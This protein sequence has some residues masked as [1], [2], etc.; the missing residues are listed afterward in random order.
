MADNL[1]SPIKSFYKGKNVFITGAT[2]FVGVT[3]VEKLLRDIP[4]IGTVYLLMRPKKGKTVA[5]RLEEIRKNSVFDKFKELTLYEKRFDKI[6]TIEGDV[7]QEHL[8]ISEAERQVLIDNVHVVFHSAATLDFFQS[9]KETTNINLLGTRRVVELCKQLTKLEALV[10]VSSA[11]VNSYITEVEEKLYPAPDDPEKVIHLAETLSD[12]ALKELEPKLL[13]DHPNTYTFTKHLA[14]HEVANV[15]SRFPC[16]IVRPSMITAAWKQPT[17]G[18]TISKNGPQ[19]FFMGASRGILRRLP[20]DPTIIMDYIPVDVVV[21]AIITTGYYVNA[22]KVKNAGKPAELQIFH[23]TSS[24]YK[25]FRFEFLINKIN[26]FLH[27]Y[28][29]VSAVWYPNLK[30]VKSLFLFRIGAILFHFIPGFFLDLVTKLSG[31]RPILIRLHKSVWNSLN[32]LE[33]FIFTEWHYDSKHTLA[34]SK[35]MDPRDREIFFID[36]GDLAWDDYFLN[37]IMGVRQYLSKESPKTLNAARKKDKILL[38]LHVALQLAFYYGIWKLA[39][40]AFGLSNAKAALILPVA[41]FLVG[42]I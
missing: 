40:V 26:A 41:Y 25:P 7:G 14:E 24:T 2:G 5:Q 27:E 36:I 35:Q 34:L 42:M 15:A 20:L 37:T 30:L 18:W 22:L 33:K 3:I 28:P 1:A 8:G 16:G 38:A 9:L 11:Y 19:G 23:L 6:V 10:H 13:K 29:L 39:I 17:P 12:E 32:T 4:E 21:N 31:G